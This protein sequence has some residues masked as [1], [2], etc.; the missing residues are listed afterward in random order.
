MLLLAADLLSP[1]AGLIFWTLVIFTVLLV[2][3][4][5]FAWGPMTSAL[6]DRERTIEESINRAEAALEEA[7]QMQADNERARREAEAEAQRILREARDAADAARTEAV[8]KERQQ[9]AQMRE[10]F[11]AEMAREK[12]Q[13][14]AELRTEVADLAVQAA[15][16]ILHE[17]LDAQ[18]QRRLVE[19]FI[20]DLPKN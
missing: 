16:K 2:V 9:V 1:H 12:D 18:R 4:G 11:Q 8:E 13:I 6:D 7:R 20:A 5:K 15:E 10:Q 14:K 3:L 19:G 17:N